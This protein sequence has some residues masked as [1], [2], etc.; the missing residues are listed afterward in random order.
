MPMNHDE[1]PAMGFASL[2][3]SYVGLGAAMP[4][5]SVGWAERSDAHQPRRGSRDG[6][7]CAHPILRAQGKSPCSAAHAAH[8]GGQQARRDATP[9]PRRARGPRNR[10]VGG[11]GATSAPDLRP[12]T[13]APAMGR[14]R[15]DFR[16]PPTACRGARATLHARR[17]PAGASIHPACSQRTAADAAAATSGQRERKI[18]AAV[19]CGASILDD[20][21]HRASK[22]NSRSPRT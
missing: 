22:K 5:T 12:G 8:L 11:R 6:V 4:I 20:P 2:T 15:S 10:G 16:S 3:P 17:V 13:A 21:G 18:Q 1:D 9:A 14:T 19:C 7:R